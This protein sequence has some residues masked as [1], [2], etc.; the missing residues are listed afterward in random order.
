M[1][2]FILFHL[3]LDLAKQSRKPALVLTHPTTIFLEKLACL[4]YYQGVSVAHWLLVPVQI[5]VGE[6]IFHFLLLSRHLMIVVKLKLNPLDFFSYSENLISLFEFISG[7][8]A[9]LS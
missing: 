2:L 6:K 3:L 8:A 5:L 1:E 4:T 7:M 9:M